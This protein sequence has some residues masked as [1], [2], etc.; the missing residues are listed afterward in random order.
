MKKRLPTYLFFL[1]HLIVIDVL[2]NLQIIN[3]LALHA[4][5][6]LVAIIVSAALFIVGWETYRYSRQGSFLIVAIGY[7]GVALVDTLH[8]LAYKGMGIL[9]EATANLPT[10]L[11]MAARFLEA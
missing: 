9:P 2:Y 8:T 7:L 6:E 4:I 3:F 11:W 10:Q 1:G 5:L